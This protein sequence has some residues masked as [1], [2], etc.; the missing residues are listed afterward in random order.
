MGMR[1]SR[2]IQAEAK[3]M[4]IESVSFEYLIVWRL[5]ASRPRPRDS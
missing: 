4:W 1:P 2:A 5:E 3:K